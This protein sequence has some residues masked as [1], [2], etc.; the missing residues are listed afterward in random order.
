MQNLLLK[1]LGYLL[2]E[3]NNPD[4]IYLSVV[5]SGGLWYIEVRKWG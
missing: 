1:K 3:M 2:Q 4:R 5:E